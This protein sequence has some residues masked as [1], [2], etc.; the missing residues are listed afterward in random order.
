MGHIYVV[1]I[2]LAQPVENYVGLETCTRE[3]LQRTGNL[4]LSGRRGA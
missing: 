2:A 1:G 4:L 3:E